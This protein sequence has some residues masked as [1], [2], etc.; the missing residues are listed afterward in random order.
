M[1]CW[2]TIAKEPMRDSHAVRGRSVTGSAAHTRRSASELE[3]PGAFQLTFLRALELP[4]TDREV[5]VLKE[6]QGY[7]LAEIAAILG[8]SIETALLRWKRA[9]RHFMHLGDSDAMEHAR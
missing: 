6:I 1:G 4:K 9:R 8:I 3:K 2:T 5:F 7:A